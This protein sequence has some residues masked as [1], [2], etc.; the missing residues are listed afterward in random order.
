M[1]GIT[2]LVLFCSLVY[3]SSGCSKSFFLLSLSNVMAVEHN[4]PS[5]QPLDLL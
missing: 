5:L 2:L 4:Q 1:S 3:T